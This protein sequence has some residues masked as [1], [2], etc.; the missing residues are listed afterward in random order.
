MP[1]H[2]A[3]LKNALPAMVFLSDSNSLNVGVVTENPAISSAY[4]MIF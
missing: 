1:A 3:V 2:K 4:P